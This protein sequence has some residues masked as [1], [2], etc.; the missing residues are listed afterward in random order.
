[1]SLSGLRVNLTAGS[2][3]GKLSGPTCAHTSLHPSIH[4]ITSKHR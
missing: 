2:Q 3:T 4:L 1:M